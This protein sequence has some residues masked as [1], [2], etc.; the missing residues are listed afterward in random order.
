MPRSKRNAYSR[1]NRRIRELGLAQ[2]Y[3]EYLKS[4]IWLWIRRRVLDRDK[5]RCRLCDAKATEVHHTN[6]S[7][8]TLIGQNLAALYAVCR[9]CHETVEFAD[10]RKLNM[11]EM[12]AAMRGL[13]PDCFGVNRELARVER[14]QNKVRRAKRKQEELDRLARRKADSIDAAETKRRKR[15][16]QPAPATKQK[17]KRKRLCHC[18]F[19]GAIELVSKTE[20]AKRAQCVQCGGKG[21]LKEGRGGYSPDTPRVAR[22]QTKTTAESAQWARRAQSSPTPYA[23]RSQSWHRDASADATTT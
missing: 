19:C 5:R 20:L 12:R 7:R 8:T 14:E 21:S 11:Q 15:E 2:T 13:R 17:A 16:E 4:D 3:Q 9:K 23:V 22:H 6:Y 10:G 1:R 18:S